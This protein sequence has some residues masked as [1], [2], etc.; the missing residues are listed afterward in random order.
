MRDERW[1]RVYGAIGPVPIYPCDFVTGFNKV[2]E[3]QIQIRIDV[4]Y[5]GQHLYQVFRIHKNDIALTYTNLWTH[6]LDSMVRQLGAALD[7]L[8]AE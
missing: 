6:T 7:E 4:W 3:N 8:D 2:L 5:K 1:E